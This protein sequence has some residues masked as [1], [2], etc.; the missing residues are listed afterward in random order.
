[1]RSPSGSVRQVH[2]V[3]ARALVRAL[4]PFEAARPG[5]QVWPLPG[6]HRDGRRRRHASVRCGRVCLLHP[7][8]TS[9]FSCRA[10]CLLAFRGHHA[11]ARGRSPHIN[12]SSL[13]STLHDARLALWPQGRLGRTPHYI[14]GPI[15][16][17][18]I[19]ADPQ[20]KARHVCS[21]PGYANHISIRN[22]C[23]AS[24]GDN[25]C[26]PPPLRAHGS[27]L[28]DLRSHGLPC[29][30]NHGRCSCTPLATRRA[31]LHPIPLAGLISAAHASRSTTCSRSTPPPPATDG[32][33]LPP[34]WVSN[35]N[36]VCRHPRRSNIGVGWRL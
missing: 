8:L 20:N 14:L 1:M 32:R 26:L 34:P 13:G 30:R 15:E 33:L 11:S 5:G 4:E 27:A 25:A 12:P 28:P 18:T 6:Q 10:P 17:L 35:V 29:V 9:P 19:S 31:P 22:P 24:A 36:L 23:R 7:P 21:W 16:H 2:S 3:H